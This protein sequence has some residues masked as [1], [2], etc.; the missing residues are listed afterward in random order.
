MKAHNY[1][2]TK[3][4]AT[5]MSHQPSPRYFEPPTVTWE[6]VT[7]L[8]QQAAELRA[9]V[10]DGKI[11]HFA[12]E[13]YS[14]KA[15]RRITATLDRGTAMRIITEA[16]RMEEQAAEMRAYLEWLAPKRY[17]C[18]AHD[19]EDGRNFTHHG[20]HTTQAPA[21]A[22]GEGED[23]IRGCAAGSALLDANMEASA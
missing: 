1:E 16:E 18:S 17:P 22:L 13:H 12:A 5:P 10:A 8:M 7:E 15:Y 3:R 21:L 14:H 20:V 6:K 9:Y 11:E 2:P 4:A 23:T 19:E